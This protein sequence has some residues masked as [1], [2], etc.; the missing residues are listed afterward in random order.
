MA[1]LL[2]AGVPFLHLR[3]ESSDLN[4]LPAQTEA[5]HAQQVLVTRFPEQGYAHIAVVVRFPGQDPLSSDNVGALYDLSRSIAAQQGVLR[6]DSV[7]DVQP[8]LDRAAYQSLYANRQSLPAPLQQAVRESVG[9]DLVVLD[10]VSTYDPQSEQARGLVRRI[11]SLPHE[12][13]QLLVT[14]TTAVELE[15][16]DLITSIA[17]WAIGFVIGVMYLVLLALLRSLL[18]PLKAVLMTVL[19][20]SASFGALVWIFQDGHLSAQLGFTP[21]AL[22]P[23]VP[24]LLFCMV[25]GLSM[26]YEVLLL[27]RMQE[28]YL[29]TRDNATAVGLG[30]ERSGRLITGAAAIMV[31]VFASFATGSVV[32]VKAV[33]LGM[34]IAVAADATIVRCVAV[35]AIMRLLGRVIWWAPGPLRHRQLA[36]GDAPGSMTGA[37]TAP[38]QVGG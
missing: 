9:R 2:L 6:V 25:F 19:S 34:A 37:E 27:S 1:V 13:G 12:Q 20:I 17:P 5:R 26:D 16:I 24:V 7:V 29:A 33:G 38:R 36:G 21:S 15:I 8:S 31:A 28:A 4:L 3:F 30:L 18:L 32:L 22:D 10:A 35:P 14:G 23:A 11:R